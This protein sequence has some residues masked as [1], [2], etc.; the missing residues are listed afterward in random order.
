[1]KCQ[2]LA[3]PPGPARPPAAAILGLIVPLDDLAALV[4]FGFLFAMWMVS[5]LVDVMQPSCLHTSH[6]CA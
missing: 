3:C 1:M 2:L 4:T 5:E 6:F